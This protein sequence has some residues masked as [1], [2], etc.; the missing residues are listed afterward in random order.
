MKN[1]MKINY[2]FPKT[3]QK[4]TKIKVFQDLNQNKWKLNS[5]LI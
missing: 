2:N 5:M 1:I 3:E 4:K